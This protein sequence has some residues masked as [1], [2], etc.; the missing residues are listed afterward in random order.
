[1]EIEQRVMFVSLTRC[2]WQFIC[3]VLSAWTSTHACI[4]ITMATQFTEQDVWAKVTETLNPL[5][6]HHYARLE[7]LWEAGCGAVV[8]MCARVECVRVHV[9]ACGARATPGSPLSHSTR[10][11]GTSSSPGASSITPLPPPLCPE[12]STT[13]LGPGRRQ[14]PLIPPATHSHCH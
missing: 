9:L 1:M 4:F 2:N 10:G 7:V 5:T 12:E 8:C 3:S 14:T 11:T 6:I 13:Q